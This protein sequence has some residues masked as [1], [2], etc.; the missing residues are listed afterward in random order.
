MEINNCQRCHYFSKSMENT[1]TIFFSPHQIPFTP[2]LWGILS[3][4]WA[5]ANTGWYHVDYSWNMQTNAQPSAKYLRNK[6]LKSI[7][8][9]TYFWGMAALIMFGCK[10]SSNPTKK[11][12]SVSLAA[13]LYKYTSS[14]SLDSQMKTL[15]SVFMF[16]LHCLCCMCINTYQNQSIFTPSN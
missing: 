16:S 12:F 10:M 13:S 8:L 2:T 15:I 5:L 11:Q 3:P 1:H 14:D 4:Q 6:I 9:A 7:S